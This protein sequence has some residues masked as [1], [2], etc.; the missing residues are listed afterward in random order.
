[1]SPT[2][3]Q[4]FLSFLRLGATAFGGPAMVTYIRRRTVEEE[5]W[6]DGRQFE[7]GVALCQMIPGATAMQTAAYVGLVTRGVTGAAACFIGFGLP[8]FLLMLMLAGLYA[9]A[10][11][12]PAVVAAFTGLQAIIVAIIANATV[13]FGQQFLRDWRRLAIAGVAAGLFFGGG[14]PFG[15]IA[16]AGLLGWVLLRTEPVASDATARLAS[17]TKP[18]VAILV[19]ALAALAGLWFVD[20]Q[21][22]QL[23]AL[24]VRVD[25][26]AFGGG[27]A[28]VPLLLHEVVQVRHWL[29][30]ATFLNGIVLGQ[31]TPGPIVITATY[32]GYLR[33]GL[34]GALVATGGVFLPSFLLVVG[35]A[36]V[37]D[38]L[39][40]SRVVGQ[41][42]GGVLCSLVGLLFTATILLAQQVGWDAGR[43]GLAV[44]GLVALRLK[45]DLLW[46]VLVGTAV[47]VAFFR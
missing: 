40:T 15:V 43:V 24:M 4:L 22:F 23:A 19:S 36:P 39:R 47:S 45:V 44:A 17:T 26:F 34:V 30:E 41:I 25:L 7:E 18:V 31:I 11:E 5:R 38:R 16:L 2:I 1:M 33:H 8:A 32:I 35:L 29:T 6:L 10:H 12:L 3:T 27:Y 21:L 28:S 46:V 14:Q 9:R 37:F 42:V 20:R 13:E